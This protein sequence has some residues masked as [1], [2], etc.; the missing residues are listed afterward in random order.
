MIDFPP[1]AQIVNY[2]RSA[3]YGP[4]GGEGEVIEGTPFL[5]YM[6]GMLFPVGEEMSQG[7]SE[8]TATAEEASP[9]AS[10]GTDSEPSTVD[11][12]EL[13][14]EALP[15]AVGISFKVPD[16]CVINCHVW[17]AQYVPQVGA[18]GKQR[19]SRQWKRN[20]LSTEAKPNTVTV[21]KGVRAQDVLGGLARV[22]PRWRSR[23][24]GT[25]IVTI[26]VVN[27]QTAPNGRG[28]DPEQTLFQV[29]LR[30]QASEGKV[31]PYPE[32]VDAHGP[33]SEDTEVVFLYQDA[34]P[35]ARG[36]GAAATWSEPRDGAC[37]WVAVD[38]VPSVDVPYATFK[39]EKKF[40]KVIDARC[41]NVKFID[42]AS[43]PDVTKALGTLVDGYRQWIE[44]QRGEPVLAGFDEIGAR[45]VERAASSLKRM[46]AG[47]QRLR[48]DDVAWKAFHLA[49]RAMGFQM[50]LMKNLR[51][52]PFPLASRP[53][54]PELQL[55]G[56]LW[57][58]FQ[59]A[60]VLTL[61]ES[62]L[63][64]KSGDRDIVDVIWFPTGG[65][66]TEAY[67]FITAL[68]LVRRRLVHGARDGA[69]A[70]L[71][72]YTM[73][74]LTAQQFQ[75]TS[76]LMVS[77]ELLRRS[78]ASLGERPFTLG[79]WVGLGLTENSFREAHEAF[80]KELESSTPTNRFV[81]L[82]CPHCGT[83]IF[84]RKPTRVRNRFQ[85]EEF[86]II[87]TQSRFA[88]RCPSRECAFHDE[89]PLNVIDEAL[90]KSPPSMLLGTI[91][92]F[93]MLAWDDRARVFFGGTDNE[94]IP[95]SLVIQDELHLI[96]GP[97]GSL[98]AP[99]EAAVDMIIGT[100]GT[101]PKR[102]GSTATIR[103]AA[104]QVRGLYGREVAVFPSPCG[105]WDNAFFFSTNR[106][107]P[108]RQYV[109]VMGQGYIKPVVAMVWT[110]AA[111][112]QSVS[113]TAVTGAALDSYWTLLAYH[114]SR[115][116]LGRTLTAAR[117]EV[118][119]RMQAIASSPARLRKLGE[120][121][122][123]S[124]QMVKSM[125]EA[126]EALE[127]KHSPSRPAEDLVPCTS[128]ISVG[129]DV[130]RLGLM[131]VNGQPKLTSEYIQATSR[132]GRGED[133]PGLVVTLFSPSKP[134]DRSHY[135]DF[136]AYH[137]SIYRHVEPTS[138]TPYALP[139]RERTF[140]AAL[141][142]L[143]R[144]ALQWHRYDSA[145]M[146]EFDAPET[147][148]A[149]EG[150]L[151]LM[152]AC[153]PSEEAALR[154]FATDRLKQWG[155]FAE[156]NNGLLYDNRQAG[157]QFPALLYVYGKPRGRALWPTMMSV[158]NVDEEIPVSVK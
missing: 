91:D 70:V 5:R 102:I 136:R 26:T 8:V 15:S 112:L 3:L 156:A 154:T 90:Y 75:R 12:M 141:V 127:R 16:A 57:R 98:A 48:K 92:K 117:D 62:L 28:L 106:D 11:E 147:K 94:S 78:D 50:V 118:P 1:R 99:Y 40:A 49:N 124:A 2:M 24:D 105:R 150:L 21:R 71:S 79:L 120:P 89:L 7:T 32:I 142:A 82:A 148:A 111:L 66:K 10:G 4:L 110:A 39:L 59:V 23:T 107:V 38:F 42:E 97:L 131:L 37:D 143:V 122:E 53:R 30:C 46:E 116:E 36:H 158:R 72:R 44:G 114:N 25:A 19:A 152:S 64:E 67:L 132:V 6:T 145:G 119:A 155:D 149:I 134:R 108:G 29:G 129:V 153:D 83:E 151:R 73:R 123:L 86:G 52:G 88:F 135:E 76:A 93:A 14:F 43:R 33:D 9:T 121:L 157:A 81:L 128:I 63:N 58:P 96:S 146:V 69:T 61:I 130:E 47:L 60:F 109:G 54:A 34:V 115:R 80:T 74:L 22:V 51:R 35:Y 100:R 113:E 140:H 84:P 137:E 17:A 45:L 56:L 144:H 31:M 18:G 133:V 103:N 77:L 138:V 20:P 139:A 65:G 126:L 95:P 85:L 104:D 68:E 87:S 101:R 125:S 13:A 55:S 27:A 41:L